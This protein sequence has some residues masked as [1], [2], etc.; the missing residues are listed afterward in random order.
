[1]QSKIH[2]LRYI[3]SIKQIQIIIRISL[4]IITGVNIFTKF[5]CYGN[6]TITNN[7]CSVIFSYCNFCY[8]AHCTVKKAF[9]KKQKPT[10]LLKAT[11]VTKNVSL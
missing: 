9:F 8:S 6:L 11:F 3:L 4:V 5:G 7:L 1:M 2:T 10:S